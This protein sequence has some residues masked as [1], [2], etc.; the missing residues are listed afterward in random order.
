MQISTIP[1]DTRV[2][3]RRARESERSLAAPDQVFDDETADE[4]AAA[5]HQTASL[6]YFF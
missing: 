3:S 4:P 1:V 5:D 2:A 6:L